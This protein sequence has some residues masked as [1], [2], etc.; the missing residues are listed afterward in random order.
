M[1][2]TE[3]TRGGPTSA[4][5][6]EDSGICRVSE[7]FF[8]EFN[9]RA[10]QQGIRYKVYVASGGVHRIDNQSEPELVAIMRS[11]YIN[12]CKNLPFDYI[13]QVRDLNGLVLDYAVPNIVSEANMRRHYLVDI[14][15][16][17][18]VLEPA[19]STSVAGF[20]T[21]RESARLI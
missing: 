5:P 21:E 10:L 3:I 9:I 11:M 7:Q 6:A 13:G 12:Y 2:R 14:N 19:V 4:I 17:L 15:T 1:L 18:A 16:P 8:S 20:K